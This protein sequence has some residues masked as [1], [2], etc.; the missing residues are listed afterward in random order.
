MV[1]KIRFRSGGIEMKYS[2]AGRFFAILV[3]CGVVLTGT[4]V[5]GAG[6]RKGGSKVIANGRKVS[7]EYTLTLE[8]GSVVDSNK[9]KQPLV[10]DQ[11]EGMIIPGL[12]SRLEGLRAGD[13]RKFEI[14][15]EEA[16]GVVDPKGIQEVPKK[17]VPPDALKVGTMLEA[18]TEDGR[19]MPLVIQEIRDNTVVVNFNHPLAGK[20]LMFDVRVIDVR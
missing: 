16:Y 3:L 9:G 6:Q 7:I 20:T 15:P 5:Q 11:G 1:Q 12:E 18:R 10:Y 2:T 14:P 19:S 8:D 13:E 4:A 17:D